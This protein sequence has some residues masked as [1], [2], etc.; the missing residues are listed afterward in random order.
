MIIVQ[1]L[2]TIFLAAGIVALVM[3]QLGWSSFLGSWS[4][5]F[6]SAI[7]YGVISLACFEFLKLLERSD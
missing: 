6:E 4:P 3:A 7:A 5:T 1:L 2:G